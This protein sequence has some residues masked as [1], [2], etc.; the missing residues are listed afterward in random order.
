MWYESPSKIKQFVQGSPSFKIKY[1]NEIETD[2]TFDATAGM[3][4]WI[5]CD[6]MK[7]CLSELADIL[8]QNN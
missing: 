8:N 2:Y 7:A 5:L 6:S 4:T 1:R 3:S